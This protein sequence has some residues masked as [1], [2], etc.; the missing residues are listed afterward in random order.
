MSN[1][2]LVY[3][4]LDDSEAVYGTARI[5][6]SSIFPDARSA[7]VFGLPTSSDSQPN[8]DLENSQKPLKI[9]K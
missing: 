9:G 7:L 3:K 2:K 4:I 8:L 5:E 6:Q 1:F